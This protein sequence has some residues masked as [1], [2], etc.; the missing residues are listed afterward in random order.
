MNMINTNVCEFCEYGEVYDNDKSRV[1]VF[2]SKKQK[3]YFYG[4]CIP[5]DENPKKRKE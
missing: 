2:C 3:M 4:Q 5:C 1:M